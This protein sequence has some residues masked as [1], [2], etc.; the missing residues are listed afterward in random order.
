MKKTA[1]LTTGPLGRQ[2]L[3][4]SIPL[5]FSNLLQILFNLVDVAVVGRY[6]GSIALGAVGSTSILIYMFTGFL[7]GLAGGINVLAALF[8]GA[9]DQKSLRET[10][11]TA[12]L[13]SL[14]TGIGLVFLGIVI[15]RPVL[16]LLKTRPELM[17]GAVLYFR[18]Y[19]LGM[20]AL[21]VYNFGNAV[22]SAAG[23]TKRPLYYLS[24]AGIVNVI[25]N[26]ILVIGF[27]LDV[28][29]VAIASAVS[30]YLSAFLIL[31]AL[32]CSREDYG[33]RAA[34]LRITPD[35]LTEILR[36]GLPAGLQNVIFHVANLFIQSAVNSFS[37]VM[38]AGNAAAANLCGIVFDVMSAFY[39][40]CGSFM[41]QNFGAKKKDRLLK[42]Y[43]ISLAYSFGVGALL[44]GIYL[45]FG[46]H[47]L[48]LFTTDPEVVTAGMQRLGIMGFSYAVS[49]VM[50]TSISASRALGKSFIPTIIVL[51]GSCVFRIIWIA[52]IFAYFRTI[53]SLYLLYIFSWLL[54]GTA[55]V[56]Y[57]AKIYKK[58][59]AHLV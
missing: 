7:I 16:A 8:L 58:Q 18:I 23:D 38:V 5:V 15:S 12:A 9:K 51:L 29:G 26:L 48:A 42:S 46:E 31:R 28:A 24:S 56:I 10:T 52:T 37:A 1:D 39:T 34:E 41:G 30:Q 55:E 40:A 50:D 13:F 43:Y 54:T 20:P 4:F 17:D 35:K 3:W 59:T 47:L 14:F 6:A 45:S 36:I 25:L 2:I 53:P 33:L 21:A 57:F 49:A 11:H 19:M 27:D 32:F 44:G 22:L